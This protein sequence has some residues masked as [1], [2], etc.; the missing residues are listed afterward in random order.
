MSIFQPTIILEDEIFV[1]RNLNPDCSS[2]GL[3][4]YKFGD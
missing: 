4:L 3:L 2:I 1:K